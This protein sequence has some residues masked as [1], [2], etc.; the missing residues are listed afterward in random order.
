MV[1]TGFCASARG[2]VSSAV[3]VRKPSQTLQ[4]ATVNFTPR[5]CSVARAELTGMQSRNIQRGHGKNISEQ[6]EALAVLQL[7]AR[8]ADAMLKRVQEFRLLSQSSYS[9]FFTSHA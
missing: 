1:P 6:A 9:P 7:L 4:G 8:Q 5:I 3:T 2:A